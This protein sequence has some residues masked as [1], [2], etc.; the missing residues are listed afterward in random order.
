[1]TSGTAAREAR[2]IRAIAFHLPQFHPIPE[3]DEWWGK[4]FTEWTNVVKARP[5]FPGHYQPHLPTD[6]GLYDLRVP[7]AR[8]AQA[9]FAREFG[10]FGFCYYHYWFNGRQVLER[11]V[12]EILQ[13]GEPDFPFCLC[14]ANHNWTRRW[15]GLDEDIL[16]EQRYSPEDDVAHIRELIPYFLDRRYIRVMG[17]PF[18]AIHCPAQLPEPRR[19]LEAWRREAERVGLE[20]LFLVSIDRGVDPPEVDPREL[21][22]DYSIQW[23]PRT[24]LVPGDARVFRRKWWQRRRL[25]TGEAPFFDNTIV[26]YEDVVRY[27]L[28]APPP[29]YPQMRCVCPGWDNSPRRTVGGTIFVGSTPEL[30]GK[31]LGE[32]VARQAARLGPGDCSM[33]SPDSLIFV[34]AWNE[35]GEGAH[36]EPCQRWGRAYLEATRGALRT[37]ASET[38]TCPVGLTR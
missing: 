33:I 37:S 14:W 11:P 2:D 8:A 12:K 28:A 24:G 27:A 6:L 35:W 9:E 5:L 3:N 7:E 32:I 4:G 16:L 18:L 1:V 38:S 19:T 15:D 29:K 21:G 10:L 34:N 25:G 36:L 31:W 30:Y 26:K 23:Q 17:R 13:S 22:F 20:G